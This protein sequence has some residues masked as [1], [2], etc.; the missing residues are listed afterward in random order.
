VRWGSGGRRDGAGLFGLVLREALEIDAAREIAEGTALARC[1][2]LG[3]VFLVWSE[4]HGDGR[5]VDEAD[6]GWK[7]GAT[8][9]TGGVSHAINIRTD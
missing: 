5:F 1:V 8:T 9:A 6:L 2:L 7:L 3:A 4:A